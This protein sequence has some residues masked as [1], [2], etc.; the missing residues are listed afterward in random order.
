MSC[1]VS[2]AVLLV[3]AFAGPAFGAALDA[4][5]LTV[6]TSDRSSVTLDVTA[7]GSGAPGGFTIEWMTLSDFERLGGWPAGGP[8]IESSE[9]T[10]IPT[11]NVTPGVT[12][13]R[14]GPGEA[15]RVVVGALFDETGT[16]GPGDAELPDGTSYVFRARAV[17]GGGQDASPDCAPVTGGTQPQGTYDCTVSAGFWKNHPQSWSRVG[18]LTLG[19]VSYD[20]TQLLAI[21]GQRAR[22]N[23]LVSLAHQLIAAKLNLMLGALPPDWI[24]R[25]IPSADA[26]IGSKV[27]PPVG[28]D[29]LAACQT[30]GMVLGLGLFNTGVLGPGH[31]AHPDGITPAQGTTWGTL[32]V[33]YR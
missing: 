2:I 13:Y 12:S 6:V 29:W 31:C 8:G 25:T 11:L 14:L 7:G 26:L 10:G 30:S 21:L 3:S 16:S 18:S 5:T 15:S 22:G 19:T 32:K 20:R 27:V 23:G 4:P 9:F 1:R 24:A 17:A 28:G 33:I